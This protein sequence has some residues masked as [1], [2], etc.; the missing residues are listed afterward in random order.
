MGRE[1]LRRKLMLGA[2]ATLLLAVGVPTGVW[3]GVTIWPRLTAPVVMVTEGGDNSSA[4]ARL[5]G[6]SSAFVFPESR[7]TWSD[8]MN[9]KGVRELHLVGTAMFRLA[10]LKEGMYVV[11]TPS[12]RITVTGTA[13]T[14]W[15]PNP[16]TTRVEVQE[17]SVLLESLGMRGGA[18]VTLLVGEQ[19]EA[20]WG[21]TAR[22]GR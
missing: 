19:G 2:A 3:L 13:F 8:R 6:A 21:T 4:T 12:A 17:G 7:L 10:P 9:T 16:S 22:R 20:V 11:E 14:V 18:P 15:M 5:D 1:K